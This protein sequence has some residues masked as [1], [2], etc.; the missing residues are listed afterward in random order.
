VS[1][2]YPS[3][4]SKVQIDV[5]SN[6]ASD[7]HDRTGARGASVDSVTVNNFRAA[8]ERPSSLIEGLQANRLSRPGD[9]DDRRARLPA[10]RQRFGPQAS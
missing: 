8:F 7:R 6:A 2:S 5:L 4:S 10:T 1:S 3:S 9:D